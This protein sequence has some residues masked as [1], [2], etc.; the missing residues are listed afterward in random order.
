MG[1]HFL[2]DLG[3]RKR[4]LATLPPGE[5][6]TWVEIGAGHGEMTQLLVAQGRRV[7]AIEGDPGLAE[8]LREIVAAR[9]SAWPG[10]EVVSGDVLALDMTKLTGGGRFRVYGNL[11]YYI[12]SPI[13]HQ[14]FG[15][16]DLIDSIHIVIQREVAERIVA[17]PMRR[18]Y[19]YLSGA[20]QFYTEPRIAL[21]LPPGAFR[22]PPKV[23]SALVAMTLPGE[24]A[25]LGIG[26]AGD[27]KRFLEFVQTCFNQKRKTLR[28]N[29][30]AMA[31]DERIHAA[32]AAAGLRPDA[33]AEQL[34]LVQFAR[35]F[36]VL[37]T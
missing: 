6:Q 36:A 5:G 12:T 35:L 4:I 28:N 7:I 19:G 9:T 23:E 8:N 17:Q 24:R 15:C 20:C 2:G 22:P 18:E 1:Q 26:N 3:W 27:E 31:S 25:G 14:L 37:A 13:L 10:V 16:A 29:L 30:R 11:P 21:R 32:T 33:R 34:T